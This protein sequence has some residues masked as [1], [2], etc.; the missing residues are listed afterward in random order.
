MSERLPTQPNHGPLLPPSAPVTS[1]SEIFEMKIPKPNL[2]GRESPGRIQ[3]RPSNFV[4]QMSISCNLWSI[5]NRDPN[6]ETASDLWI[7]GS[8]GA[9]RHRGGRERL[10]GK[11][12]RWRTSGRCPPPPPRR[13]LPLS[14]RYSSPAPPNRLE[15]QSPGTPLCLLPVAERQL[16]IFHHP[17]DQI[18][19]QSNPC[20][21]SPCAPCAPGSSVTY[22]APGGVQCAHLLGG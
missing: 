14:G 3:G 11:V 5:R 15:T 17:S 16:P 22:G 20:C 6:L 10:S 9:S 12:I 2:S 18:Q 8:W 4:P 1:R 13:S 19:A 21:A 7:S